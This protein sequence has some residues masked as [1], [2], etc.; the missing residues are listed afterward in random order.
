MK[1][2]KYIP[3][4]LLKLLGVLLFFSI[5]GLISIMAILGVDKMVTETDL[6][7]DDTVWTFE[8]LIPLPISEDI[9]WFLSGNYIIFAGIICMYVLCTKIDENS[10][11]IKL[12]L[13]LKGK[14]ENE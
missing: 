3:F 1:I 4:R 9:M 6:F 10:P 2:K 5:T 13:S 8:F 11:I 14:K 7:G 12:I